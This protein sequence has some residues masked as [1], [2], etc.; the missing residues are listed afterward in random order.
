VFREK[1]HAFVRKLRGVADLVYATA[2]HLVDAEP[3]AVTAGRPIPRVP[4]DNLRPDART[5]WYPERREGDDA[6]GAVFLAQRRRYVGWDASRRYLASLWASEGPFQYVCGFSQGAVAVHQLLS[7][8]EARQ[9]HHRRSHGHGHGSEAD[10]HALAHALPEPECAAILAHPPAA[11]ILVCGFPSRSDPAVL[12]PGELLRTPTLHVGSPQDATVAPQWQAELVTCFAAPRT[13]AHDKGH[14]M[15][16]RA[17]DLAAVV[18]FLQ[19][20]A[21]VGAAVS[22]AAATPSVSSQRVGT[23]TGGAAASAAVSVSPQPSH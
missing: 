22:T 21:G 18:D 17:A 9:M 5:W 1:T 3:A 7:E 6:V 4:L 15:P 16:Q 11:A 23:P 10:A 14:A 19:A 12:P 2:P 13:L 20:H 8:L